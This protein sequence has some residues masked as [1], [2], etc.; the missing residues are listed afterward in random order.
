MFRPD[1]LAL[2]TAS[3][4]AA[5]AVGGLALAGPDRA[6][7]TLAGAKAT[8][9]VTVHNPK[10]TLQTG[11]RVTRYDQARGRQSGYKLVTRNGKKMIVKK[12][13]DP[14]PY[15]VRGRCGSSWFTFTAPSGTHARSFTFRT[16]YNAVGPVAAYHWEWRIDGPG[17]VGW[18]NGLGGG[19]KKEFSGRHAIARHGT[20]S[21][22][23][24]NAWVILDD[25]RVCGSLHP[26]DVRIF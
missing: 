10:A 20:Y 6:S 15:E 19:A 12:G 21:G 25:G 17:S 13:K 26:T 24:T 9:L 11:L 16:G 22:L 2:A 14:V 4:G 1:Y 3:L 5:V 8:P 23:V 7:T 18:A